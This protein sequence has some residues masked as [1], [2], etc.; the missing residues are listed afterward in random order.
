MVRFMARAGLALLAAVGCS[1]VAAQADAP[2]FRYVAI[3]DYPEAHFPY[4]EGPGRVQVLIGHSQ[5]SADEAKD[6]ACSDVSR[7]LMS[8]RSQRGAIG[9]QTVLGAP[10]ETGLK[11]AEAAVATCMAPDNGTTCQPPRFLA[12]AAARMDGE[13]LY[14]AAGVACNGRSKAAA[15]TAALA[16]CNQA[17][18]KKGVTAPCRIM[19]QTR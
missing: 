13:V 8:V 6:S 5:V 7:H 3:F 15:E 11:I 4:A 9:G 17:R 14:R 16:S 12:T 18:A 10:Y 19:G 2:R 1:G